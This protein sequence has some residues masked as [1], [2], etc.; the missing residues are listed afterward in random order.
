M[1]KP[2]IVKAVKT[3][4]ALDDPVN[5]GVSNADAWPSKEHETL[6]AALKKDTFFTDL[7]LVL[8]MNQLD[9]RREINSLDPLDRGDFTENM[10]T[11]YH[12]R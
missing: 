12:I 10:K 11:P 2:G 3:S 5:R 9:L 8:Q 4:T 1:V 7:M 6:K